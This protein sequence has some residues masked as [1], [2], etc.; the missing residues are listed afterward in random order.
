V[1]I[2]MHE[3]ERENAVITK[4]RWCGILV[5]VLFFY[6]GTAKTAY[7]ELCIS[8]VLLRIIFTPWL[9]YS[10]ALTKKKYSI[11][12]FSSWWKTF[13]STQLKISKTQTL[14]N[15]NFTVAIINPFSL[16]QIPYK[17]ES[18]ITNPN[19]CFRDSGSTG[20]EEN[21]VQRHWK[22]RQIQQFTW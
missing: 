16:L 22:Q 7:K 3:T 20:D 5:Q 14:E 10:T 8:F 11:I 15:F 21:K 18:S 4:S 1:K 17:F 19:V 13:L 12:F 2:G 9:K 6:W